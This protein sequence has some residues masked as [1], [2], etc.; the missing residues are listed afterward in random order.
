MLNK[1]KMSCLIRLITT[2]EMGHTDQV[3]HKLAAIALSF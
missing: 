2:M 3:V 1:K